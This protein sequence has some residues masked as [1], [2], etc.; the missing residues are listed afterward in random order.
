MASMCSLC[1]SSIE[2]ITHLFFECRFARN[3]WALFNKTSNTNT[4]HSIDNC[5][6]VLDDSISKISKIIITT[7][8]CNVL[9]SIWRARNNSRFNGNLARWEICASQIFS[10]VVLVGKSVKS[11]TQISTSYCVLMKVKPRIVKE[12]IWCPPL[13]NWIKGN[14]DGASIGN[15]AAAGG[16]FHNS[17]GVHMG[18]FSCFLGQG[19]FFFAEITGAILSIE[20]AIASHWQCFWLET[21]SIFVIH[22]I[23]NLNLVPWSIRNHWYNSL[24]T[25]RS[26]SFLATHIYR[27]GNYCAYILASLTLTFKNFT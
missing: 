4:I 19:D 1:K 23:S 18:S 24:L 21:N 16:I 5:W 26:I 10:Q 20:H 17:S 25:T 22:S 27:E 13:P 12:V 11:T 8:F 14:S 3:L 15:L 2:T 7:G 6:R 9:M